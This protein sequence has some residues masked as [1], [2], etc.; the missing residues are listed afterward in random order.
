MKLQNLINFEKLGKIKREK[1][2]LDSI[3]SRYNI[4]SN[5]IKTA[6]KLLKNNNNDESVYISAY[7]ELYSSFRILCEVMLALCSYRTSMGKG[8]HD[9]A[10]SSIWI[11]L[12]DDEMKPAYLRLKKIGGKRNDMEYGGN[13]DISSLEMKTMLE[14]VESVL[15]KVGIEIDKKKVS[16][17]T[18][19]ET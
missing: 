1:F 6:E 19:S 2:T 11:T 4:V 14:D 10:I 12:D 9:S 18:A 5:R 15:Q 3:E 17:N 13:F 16:E 8:H 7:S